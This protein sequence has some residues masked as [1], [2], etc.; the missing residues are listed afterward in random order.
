MSKRIPGISAVNMVMIAVVALILGL[1]GY[2][3]YQSYAIQHRVAT[4]F[5]GW[6]E[7]SAGY[8]RIMEAQRTSH[9]PVIVY[10]YAPWCPHCKRFT[11]ELLSSEDVKD[12]LKT[13][14]RVRVYP[15][16]NTPELTLMESFGA[17]GFPTFYVVRPDGQRVK[18]D[19]HEIQSGTGEPHLKTP[20]EFI[21]SVRQAAGA[22]K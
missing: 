16:E 20:R 8:A 17:T 2:V 22:A 21:E 5:E 4:A 9:R 15:Q 18:V 7:G 13:Y 19:T 12:Y 6:E 14:P 10:F 11:R 3:V 1:S